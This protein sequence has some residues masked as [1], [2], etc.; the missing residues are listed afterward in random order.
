MVEPLATASEKVLEVSQ[1][2]LV[3]QQTQK[4]SPLMLQASPGSS[5]PVF[6]SGLKQAD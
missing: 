5:G 4:P 1:S 6:S 3:R 2:N